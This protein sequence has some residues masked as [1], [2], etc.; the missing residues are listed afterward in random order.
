VHDVPELGAAGAAGAAEPPK[1]WIHEGVLARLAR[2]PARPWEVGGWLLGFWTGDERELFVT[3]AMPPVGRGTPF[4]VRISGAGHRERFDE[5]WE[6]SGGRITFVGDWH[7]H[8][9]CPATPSDRDLAALLQLSDNTDFG[10]RRPL[11]GIVQMPRWPFSTFPREV[12]W[13]LFDGEEVVRELEPRVTSELPEV[14]VAIPD[15][16]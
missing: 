14:A 12:R 1:L 7:T 9:G 11:A 5:A 3:H 6:A 13:H 15:W 16:E 8:P 4:G 10:T 2:L